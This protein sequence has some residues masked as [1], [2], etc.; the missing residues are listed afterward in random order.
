MTFAVTP[1][2]WRAWVLAHPRNLA[3]CSTTGWIS[4]YAGE[5][6]VLRGGLGG[7]CVTKGLGLLAQGIG[8]FEIWKACEIGIGGAESVAAFDSEGGE[9]SIGG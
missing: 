3:T 6:N 1:P 9:V 2:G 4:A 7:L 8:P 5:F